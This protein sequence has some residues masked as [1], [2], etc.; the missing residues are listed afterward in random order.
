[1]AL[2]SFVVRTHPQ[3]FVLSSNTYEFLLQGSR[4]IL[5][6]RIAASADKDDTLIFPEGLTTLRATSQYE[7]GQ[8]D[9][10]IELNSIFA[11][12]A[13]TDGP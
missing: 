9:P 10:G 7:G 11:Y 8:D 2:Y 13:G 1:M 4:L 12:R 6:L 3:R 5:N